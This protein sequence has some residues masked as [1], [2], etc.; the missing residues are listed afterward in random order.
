MCVKRFAIHPGEI[1]SVN[2]GDRHYVGFRQLCGLYGVNPSECVDMSRHTQGIRTDNLL[3]LYV[4]YQ[5]G[6]YWHISDL[7]RSLYPVPDR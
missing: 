7:E 6:A 5:G 3:H 4:S 2:D 1:F